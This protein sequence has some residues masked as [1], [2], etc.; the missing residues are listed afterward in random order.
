MVVSDFHLEVSSYGMQE[1]KGEE[2]E[3]FLLSWLKREELQGT[4]LE[5][6]MSWEK[7]EFK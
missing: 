4:R 2:E 1:N 7:K 3:T 5:R 6:E